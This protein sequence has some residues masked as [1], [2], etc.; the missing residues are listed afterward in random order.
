[1]IAFVRCVAEHGV[2]GLVEMAP[3]GSS[4]P[5]LA[6]AGFD[7][8][9]RAAAEAVRDALPAGTAD[10]D[11]LTLELYLTQLPGAVRQTLKR[12]DDPTGTT[13]PPAFDLAS[14]DDVL[15]LL[16]PRP[17]RF[18]PGQPLWPPPGTPAS[19][20]SSTSTSTATPRG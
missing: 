7:D 16:P 4:P 19:S 5:T 18:A 6:R 20:R 8:A 12:P 13:V 15:K 1:M 14:P 17:P 3:A 2:R 10:A 11:R 9:R